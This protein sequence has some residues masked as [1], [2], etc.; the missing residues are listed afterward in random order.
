[1]AESAYQG[2]LSNIK[3]LSEQVA[4]VQ[5]VTGVADVVTRGLDETL[6]K[7]K[8]G[9]KKIKAER[10][11][12]RKKKRHM[13][14]RT[15]KQEGHHLLQQ[16]AVAAAAASAAAAS[17]AHLTALPPAAP[18]PGQPAMIVG[19]SNI[20][21]VLSSASEE[22]GRKRRQ[23]PESSVAD[24]AAD[25]EADEDEEDDEEDEEAV[26]DGH[27]ISPPLAFLSMPR[28]AVMSLTSP[29]PV[30]PAIAPS[31][32][33]ALSPAAPQPSSL[34]S[35]AA[36]PTAYQ[37]SG[38]GLS[39]AQAPV[40][41]SCSKFPIAILNVPV[42]RQYTMTRKDSK[43]MK[44]TDKEA[45]VNVTVRIMGTP[46]RQHIYFV[47]KDVCQLICL[48]K[49]SVAKAIHDF[50]GVE[51]ARMPVLCQRS[52]GSGC[53]QVLTVLTMA[54]VQR[55]MTSSR[56]PIARSV[57]QWLSERVTEIQAGQMPSTA[58]D[59]NTV[60]QTT[61]A[62]SA[63]ASHT[64]HPTP[65]HSQQQQPHTTTNEP[66]TNLF[67]PQ[68][69]QLPPPSAAS[70]G[71]LYQQYGLGGGGGDM[72]SGGVDVLVSPQ[73]GFGGGGTRASLSISNYPHF[74]LSSVSSGT[75][76]SSGAH[77]LA[78]VTQFANHAFLNPTGLSLSSFSPISSFTSP[79]TSSYQLPS[80]GQQPPQQQ[81]QQ[82][83]SLLPL[84]YPNILSQLIGAA[85]AGT[86][87]TMFSGAHHQLQSGGGTAGH[88]LFLPGSGLFSNLG[89]AGAQRQSTTQSQPGTALTQSQLSQ[90]LA[91]QQ[92]QQ[93]SPVQQHQQQQHLQ[94]QQQQQQH[95]QQQQQQQ[96]QQQLN[97]RLADQHLGPSSL[98]LSHL[99]P[100]SL[101][102]SS[103]HRPS[104]ASQSFPSA[105]AAAAS[106][107]LSAPSTPH[108]NQPV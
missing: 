86:G 76:Q 88:S 72:G 53:T 29:I 31:A 64:Q 58:F 70:L 2:L 63:S 40:V 79:T 65:T 91:L 17:T 67:P 84:T 27:I 50:T 107:Y 30:P 97:Q 45:L 1:M 69:T 62:A 42:Q 102:A 35:S 59:P 13:K 24:A 80:M 105:A 10:K 108:R 25:D 106:H 103:H 22:S 14:E 96:L 28:L 60:M 87:S 6:E 75:Q 15:M 74:P 49:G 66:T 23:L 54:G 92:Q 16:A 56:Q 8:R 12:K 85:G 77:P 5:A 94:Q 36:P 34:S 73:I 37:P 55:L 68:P 3:A 104:A 19:G 101:S 20:L 89:N 4:A 90:L 11:K 32:T 33:S 51:K 26:G 47:A 7:A 43:R 9:W 52:S 46:D 71:A 41:M 95:Q 21:Q 98:S 44:R 93:Q 81:Q 57:L 99:T 61:D 18:T 100:H 48:R 78:S 83:Q 38:D 82:A 39:D